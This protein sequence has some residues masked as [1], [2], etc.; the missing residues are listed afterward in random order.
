MSQ[1]ARLR[2]AQITNGSII[3]ADDLNAEINQLVNESNTQDTRITALES[4]DV[5]ISG[6]KSFSNTAGIKTNTITERSS[7]S[8]VTIVG[9]TSKVLVD[10]IT[11]YTS[12][13]AITVT[14]SIIPSI[15]SDPGAPSEGMLWY[16]STTHLLKYRDNS[17]TQQVATG[18]TGRLL[19]VN[20]YTSS[21]TWSKPAGTTAVRVYSVGG[22]GGGGGGGS[23]TTGGG[24]G[25]GAYIDVYITASIGATETVTIGTAGTA[26]AS[27]N[28]AGGNGGASTYGSHIS[29]AGGNGGAGGTSGT[30]GTGGAGT[31]SDG[32][33][34]TLTGQVGQ[35]GSG[36]G[37]TTGQGGNSLM[38]LGGAV[39]GAGT[40]VGKVGTGYGA[41]GSGGQ[42]QA[43]GAGT[44][45]LIIVESYS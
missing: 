13:G 21:A 6:V 7:G 2:S 37:G 5:T 20:Y 17:A 40:T 19:A 26:G 33:G 14:G 38:G 8:G 24:G 4:G 39:S 35:A 36:S 23:S 11:P 9:S 16:N 44:K 3:D 34:I 22:G 15:S 41:G 29:A 10:H 25:A 42:N 45:G 27:G 1:I 43:G 32:T 28:N 30:G 18:A 12:G 31:I